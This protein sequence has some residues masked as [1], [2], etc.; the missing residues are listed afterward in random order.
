MINRNATICLYK[1]RRN[2]QMQA[3]LSQGEFL[4]FQL[5]KERKKKMHFSPDDDCIDCALVSI[6]I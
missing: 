1:E 4:C 2:N 3:I 5:K 6:S